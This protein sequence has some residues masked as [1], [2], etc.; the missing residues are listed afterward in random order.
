[1]ILTVDTAVP[2]LRQTL[3][4]A[5]ECENR[6]ANKMEIIQI[7][8]ATERGGDFSFKRAIVVLRE[9]LKK[10]L[11]YAPDI[12]NRNV[13]E[14]VLGVSERANL[15]PMSHAKTRERPSNGF[16]GW[17]LSPT[18]PDHAMLE[19]A[20]PSDPNA[21]AA[22]QLINQAARRLFINDYALALSAAPQAPRHIFIH[23][24]PPLELLVSMAACLDHGFGLMGHEEQQ[25]QL[26]EMRKVYDEV[27]GDGYFRQEIASMY[28]SMVRK[29]GDAGPLANFVSGSTK[30][31][32]PSQ[33][34]ESP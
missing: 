14:Y 26:N 19:A 21:S 24:T 4:E 20:F 27:V 9:V 15:L 11:L 23:D 3:V 10:V 7:L 5:L 13:I 6:V 32:A 31:S 22:A 16:D 33:N 12:R 2:L 25:K 17:Q 8:D 28:A 29:I 1:M 18:N 30:Q 34:A